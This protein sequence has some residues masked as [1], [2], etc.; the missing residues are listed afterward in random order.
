MGPRDEE[1]ATPGQK[2]S[3][4]L[5]G[6]KWIL[7]SGDLSRIKEK[8]MKLRVIL[9]CTLLL[10]AAAPSFA[11]PQCQEC[12]YEWN[13]CDDVSGAFQR[14]KYDSSGHCYLSTDR[15]SPTLTQS[16]VLTD[17]KVASIETSCPAQDAVTVATPAAVTDVPS[18]TLMP[19]TTELK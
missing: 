5:C 17:W 7:P 18:A 11:L 9:V 15:C 16:T 6:H 12:N 1:V 2:T 13:S 3:L 4:P 14:C 19:Q 10:L 8:T